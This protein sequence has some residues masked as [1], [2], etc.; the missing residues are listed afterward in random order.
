[1][2]AAMFL[3]IARVPPGRRMGLCLGRQTG[4]AERHK[5][6]RKT[7]R[8]QIKNSCKGAERAVYCVEAEP[9]NSVFCAAHS[10]KK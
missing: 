2:P 8:I 4:K 7:V 1:M 10:L 9:G 5:T 3:P 6:G